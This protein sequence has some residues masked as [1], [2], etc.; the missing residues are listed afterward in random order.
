VSRF[1]EDG[2]V[3]LH[4]L[5]G[6]RR[7]LPLVLFPGQTMPVDSYFRV[8]PRLARR[9]HVFAVDVHGHG[10]SSW[11]PERYSFQRMGEDM[12]GLLAAVV[13]RPAVVSGNS[14]GGVIAVWLAANAPELVRAVAPEDP[15]LFSCEWPRLKDDCFVYAMFERCMEAL[16]RPEGRDVAGFFSGLEVPVQG[17]LTPLKLPWLM[18]AT[19]A[20]YVRLYRLFVPEGPIDLGLAPPTLRVWIK[21]LSE[22]DPRFTQA[23]LDGAATRGFSHE[24]ALA[25]IDCPVLLIHANWF[26]H[27][28]LGLVGAM[29]DD[30]VARARALVT[31]LRYARVDTAHT[32][33]LAAPEI[34]AQLLDELADELADEPSCV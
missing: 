23:F 8:L 17:R 20:L 27:E 32:V 21:G 30:D 11:N 28:D 3:R 22:Y 7:E 19:L 26:R 5:E 16:A 31:D 1:H 2:D 6:P 9:F 33:H 4:Y 13:G 18:S 15:P 10:Q 34:F 14:S 12:A 29:D 25:R 24:E